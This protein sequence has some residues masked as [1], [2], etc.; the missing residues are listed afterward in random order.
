MALFITNTEKAF[1][2]V[3]CLFLRS[4]FTKLIDKMMALY[5][6][7]SA[8]IKTQSEELSPLN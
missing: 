2:R 5:S 8:N 6:N 1:D 4:M 7:Q 3:D